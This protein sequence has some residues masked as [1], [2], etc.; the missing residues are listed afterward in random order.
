MIDF[1]VPP[2]L[3]SVGERIA[4]FIRDEVIPFEADP[5]QGP[6]GPSEELRR[7]L[8]G[9]SR[10]AGLLS[11]HGPAEW[12]GLGLDHV[13]IAI[14][15]EQAGYSPLGPLALN[16]QAP[17][18]GNV[19]LLNVV[20]TPAQKKRWLGP[21]VAGEIRTVFMMTE[22]NNGAGSDPSLLS[23]VARRHGDHFVIDGLKWLITGYPDSALTIIL[24]RAL[25][26][27]GADLG[28]TMFLVPTGTPGIRMVRML[29]SI[30]SN[31]PGGHAVM[32]LEGLRVGRED[33]LGEVGHGFRHAQVR[34]GPA[35][36]THCMRWLGQ[37]RRCHDIAAAYA[38]RRR[39]FGRPIG[40]HQGVG[41][42]LADNDIDLH[43]AR[44]AI[45]HCA[46]MLDQGERARTETS[47]CK[48][49]CSE[50]L[51]RVVDRS[52]QVLGGLGITA[53]TVVERTY[54]DIR[55]FR[56]YDGPS[57]VHRHVLA[58]DAMRN[59][60]TIQGGVFGVDPLTASGAL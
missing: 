53:D 23:T 58:R 51:G 33:V 59:A 49:F 9:R 45:L 14:A 17:D 40:E 55:C 60:E 29:D 57:E 1:S 11:P 41:F 56:I 54:R 28:A 31:S 5:R 13:G 37:A 32:A 26:E 24:A 42:Q 19:N 48:V 10:R 25:D 20:A 16:I 52:M 34:L 38:G 43:L 15:F 39:S 18:E 4:A 8:V 35:R 27:D 50:A 44:L 3:A 47:R 36:L 46:W 2:E 12:G 6:H 7:E 30:D 21:L 22:P